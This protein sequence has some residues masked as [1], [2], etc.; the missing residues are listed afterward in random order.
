VLR[1]IWS[2]K[3]FTRFQSL[4]DRQLATLNSIAP[5]GSLTINKE[6]LARLFSTNDGKDW[7]RYAA[8]LAN[9]I[10]PRKAVVDSEMF[11]HTGVYFPISF[12]FYSFD[13][14]FFCSDT[15]VE[16]SSLVDVH[17]V[18]EIVAEGDE[19]NVEEGYEETVEDVSG[20]L[21]GDQLGKFMVSVRPDCGLKPLL[22]VNVLAMM[23]VRE[24]SEGRLNGRDMGQCVLLSC[25]TALDYRRHLDVTQTIMIPFV[26]GDIEF[27]HI[28][29]ARLGK[30]ETFPQS[31]KYFLHP[32]KIKLKKSDSWPSWLS[33]CPMFIIGFTLLGGTR[34]ISELWNQSGPMR[35]KITLRIPAPLDEV[36]LL[37]AMTH[38][39][40]AV[41][42][43]ATKTKVT[44]EVEEEPSAVR[45]PHTVVI[46]N[47][48]VKKT[49]FCNVQ[50][51]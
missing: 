49:Q 47:L 35:I 23:V 30:N 45:M 10:R 5:P 4:N 33:S 42:E 27:A 24:D 20:V 29:V 15:T 3:M 37:G 7:A 18:K 31:G 36:E 43:N 16:G 8:D 48:K 22:H 51:K 13:Q 12:L 41:R 26:L 40:Q 25:M 2:A 6:P 38:E 17:D 44:E 34:V 14:A 28:F 9:V 50:N 32:W 11:L 1:K 21:V 46:P 39:A 19:E